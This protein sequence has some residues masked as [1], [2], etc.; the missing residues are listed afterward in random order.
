V[1]VLEFGSD[2]RKLTALCTECCYYCWFWAKILGPY[3]Q[4]VS[5]AMFL[6]VVDKYYEPLVLRVNS[7]VET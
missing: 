5:A 7:C 3:I 6:C 4:I 2:I 1:S